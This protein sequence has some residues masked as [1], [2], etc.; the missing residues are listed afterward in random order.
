MAKND[1]TKNIT[2][3]DVVA[4]AAEKNLIT[5]PTIP[6]QGKADDQPE[7]TVIEGEGK[8][9]L[10]D[11]MKLAGQRAKDNKKALLITVGVVGAAAFVGF[12]LLAKAAIEE[13][14][15]SSDSGTEGDDETPASESTED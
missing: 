2:A 7:L 5:D 6:A 4:E 8:K 1:N 3:D 15:E 12:K 11:R 10:K 14:V 13:I 9:S